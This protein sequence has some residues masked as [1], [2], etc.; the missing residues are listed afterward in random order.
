MP[1]L[2]KSQMLQVYVTDFKAAI[3]EMPQVS[4]EK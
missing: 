3:L 2:E 4:A 1:T